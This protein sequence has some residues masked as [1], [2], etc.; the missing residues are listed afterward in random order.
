MINRFK[1]IVVDDLMTTNDGKKQYIIH[2][3]LSR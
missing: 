1:E 2:L 3:K